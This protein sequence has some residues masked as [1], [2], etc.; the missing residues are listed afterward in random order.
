MRLAGLQN[1]GINLSSQQTKKLSPSKSEPLIC[2]VKGNLP[3]IGNITVFTNG[4]NRFSSKS[5]FLNLFDIYS[6]LIQL[7]IL[8]SA[9]SRHG[10]LVIITGPFIT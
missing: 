6:R 2:A 7:T 9:G 4:S 5:F 10:F 3:F 1:F 8:I